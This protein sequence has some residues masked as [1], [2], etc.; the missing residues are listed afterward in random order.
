MGVL[1]TEGW[2]WPYDTI[3]CFLVMVG[4]ARPGLKNLQ[5]PDL[6]G[7]ALVAMTKLQMILQSR[8][9]HQL[10]E[11]CWG[12]PGWSGLALRCPIGLKLLQKTRREAAEGEREAN[13]FSSWPSSSSWLTDQEL[14]F[15]LIWELVGA[16]QREEKIFATKR[17]TGSITVSWENWKE[18]FDSYFVTLVC[19]RQ[20]HDEKVAHF[21]H[22]TEWRSR[23][24]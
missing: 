12:F 23:V 1:L 21:T 13:S 5:I 15:H 20:S 14:N 9:R 2:N 16:D 22:V 10:I 11:Y 19:S 6:H 24:W 7:T 18:L 4:S 8:R 17:L 3:P